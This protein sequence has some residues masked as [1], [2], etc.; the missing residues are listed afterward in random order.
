MKQRSSVDAFKAKM[1]ARMALERERL[2]AQTKARIEK[3]RVKAELDLARY[4]LKAEARLKLAL[5]KQQDGD[6]GRGRVQYG[7]TPK[8]PR[9]REEAGVR[10]DADVN[11][12]AALLAAELLQGK[13]RPKRDDAARTDG[14]LVA[15]LVVHMVR[16]PR[17]VSTLIADKIYAARDTQEKL[18]FQGIAEAALLEHMAKG[19]GFAE[20]A[21]RGPL[22]DMVTHTI[23]LNPDLTKA[24]QERVHE[25]KRQGFRRA[26]F[27]RLA[28][29][30]I[31]DYL[32]RQGWKVA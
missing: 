25:S 21:P 4:K 15:E 6:K 31:T 22:R 7:P 19:G 5:A 29:A 30:A 1:E 18:S 27:Q 24:I 28:E 17:D 13:Y 32:E 14:H 10:E 26:S 3:I 20:I 8:A 12:K 16:L 11:D 9:L 2:E 23:R